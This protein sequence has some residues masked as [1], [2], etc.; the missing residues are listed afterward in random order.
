MGS[1]DDYGRAYA[2]AVERVKRATDAEIERSL[3]SNNLLYRGPGERLA[4][5][6]PGLGRKTDE[7]K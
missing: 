1:P 3:I 6:G 4:S 7:A 2:A 5:M